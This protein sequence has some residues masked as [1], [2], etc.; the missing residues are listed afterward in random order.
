MSKNTNTDDVEK[1]LKKFKQA[2]GRDLNAEEITTYNQGIEKNFEEFV[3]RQIKEVTTKP[4]TPEE[5][6]SQFPEEV[7]REAETLR[8]ARQ[9][10]EDTR[11]HKQAQELEAKTAELEH[12]QAHDIAEWARQ[13]DGET[14]EHRTWRQRLYE[15]NSKYG[16]KAPK[17]IEEERQKLRQLYN[18]KH[19]EYPT[20]VPT[21]RKV[22]TYECERMGLKLIKIGN[23]WM[24]Q[25]N[26]EHFKEIPKA[27]VDNETGLPIGY[28]FLVHNAALYEFKKSG[29]YADIHIKLED[30]D[31]PKIAAIPKPR[32]QEPAYVC[33]EELHK[34][35]TGTDNVTRCL[36]CGLVK[37]KEK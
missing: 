31:T 14:E 9:F 28:T 34:F 23:R 12:K 6:V 27:I 24:V 37:K 8:I 19:Y 22:V 21:F 26:L 11:I 7:A 13:F 20:I 32:P 4:L 18:D 15:I 16:D 25:G 10:E 29:M 30:E 36:L 33:P 5:R 35:Q 3:N 2:T 1:Q 17:T